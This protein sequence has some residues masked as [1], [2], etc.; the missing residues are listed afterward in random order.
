MIFEMKDARHSNK[1]C[2][3]IVPAYN[4]AS[5]LP[6]VLSDLVKNF[7][8]IV[9]VNDGSTDKTGAVVKAFPVHLLSHPFNLGQGAALQTGFD[10]AIGKEALAIISMDGDGQMSSEEIPSL[11]YPLQAGECDVTLGTRFSKGQALN[12]PWTRKML[13]RLAVWFTRLSTGL[14]ITDTHNGFRGF[15][16]KALLSIRLRQ[17]RMAHASEILQQIA[18]FKLRYLEIPVTIR[19]TAGSLREGQKNINGLNILWDLLFKR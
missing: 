11:L 3:I 16:R 10:Y 9:V 5:T 4:C 13:L 15:T 1:D 17:N 12:I 14:S 7:Q 19:Y 18:H 2:W 6:A 8:N